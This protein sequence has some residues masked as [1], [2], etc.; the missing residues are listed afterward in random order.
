MTTRKKRGREPAARRAPFTVQTRT[1]SITGAMLEAA[2]RGSCDTRFRAASAVALGPVLAAACSLAFPANGVQCTTTS[3]CTARGGAFTGSVCINNVC[4]PTDAGSLHDARHDVTVD[5]AR[6][7][8]SDAPPAGDWSCLGHVRWPDASAGRELLTVPYVNLISTAPIPGVRVEPCLK[9]D[10]TCAS[11]LSEAGLTNDAGLVTLSVPSGYDGY[12][13]SL[14]DAGFPSLVYV[15]PPILQS[16]TV[17]PKLFVPVTA[18]PG[19]AA[20]VGTADGGP[21]IINPQRGILFLGAYDCANAP[22]AGVSFSLPLPEPTSTFM[23]L[24]DGVPSSTATRTDSSGAA[25]IA[26]VPTGAVGVTAT[27]AATHQLIGTASAFSQPGHITFLSL[28]PVP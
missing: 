12:L 14:W 1:D 21:L 23:Y 20:A 17:P 5:A 25:V 26:N 2:R 27:L 7:V 22:A 19:L 15:N 24:I 8:R 28:V 4:L 10:P 18:L 13:L 16:Q 6:D 9:L 3:D 11:P